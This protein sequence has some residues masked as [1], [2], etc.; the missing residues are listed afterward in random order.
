MY[1]LEI[2]LAM[3]LRFKAMQS[4]A[5]AAAFGLAV[6]GPVVLG[7]SLAGCSGGTSSGSSASGSGSAA[8]G[9]GKQFALIPMSTTDEYWKAVHAGAADAV[10][11]VGLPDSALI[12]QGPEKPDD[13]MSEGRTVENMIARGVSGI[14][15]APADPQALQSP[16]SEAKAKQIPV[17]VIDSPLGGSDYVS[18]VGTDNVKAGEQAAD[19]MAKLIGGKGTVLML[20]MKEGQA[21]TEARG[22][23]FVKEM[24]A[25]Y[26]G[27]TIVGNHQYGGAVTDEAFRKS[28]SLL[29]SY[30]NNQTL[31]IQGIFCVNEPTTVGMLKALQ[32]D[33]LIGKAKFVGFDSSDVLNTALSSGQI[34]ALV[35]QDPYTIGY[36]GFM[37][38][39]NC[40]KGLKYEKL[41][42]T[43]A[44]VITHE[45]CGTPAN[46]KL[47]NPKRL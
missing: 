4:I 47:L 8:A 29:Q 45:D 11:A 6:F 43:P 15:L 26:P 30:R 14:A 24:T 34:D 20:R 31:T 18:F 17:V 38:L 23:G 36:Q 2:P 35:V 39:Y 40:S 13:P 12:F 32:T 19:E 42:N 28:E 16:V 5:P 46:Q 1:W 7:L 9:G 27:I 3:Q 44:T 10:K 37:E 21:S 33:D 22:D 41:V 25:K